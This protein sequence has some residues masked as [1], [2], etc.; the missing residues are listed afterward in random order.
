MLLSVAKLSVI[1]VDTEVMHEV[2]G[3]QQMLNVIQVKNA[4]EEFGFDK[5]KQQV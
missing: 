5:D 3:A 4:L 2:F 1:S